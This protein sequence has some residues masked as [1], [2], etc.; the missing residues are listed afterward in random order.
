MTS[1][2]DKY[3][4][5]PG[6]SAI[7]WNNRLEKDSVTEVEEITEE[8]F[9]YWLGV[10]PP[11]NWK[12]YGTH[13]SFHMQEFEFGNVTRIVVNRGDKYYSF[14]DVYSMPHGE[15]MKK[16]DEYVWSKS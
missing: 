15:I 5:R 11:Q 16:V 14:H 1:N 4:E 6:E 10:L 2:L 7:E 9:H 8:S 12:N 3:A 13:G